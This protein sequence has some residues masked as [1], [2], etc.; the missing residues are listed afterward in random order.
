MQAYRELCRPA[1]ELIASAF[2]FLP[3]E[4]V[5]NVLGWSTYDQVDATTALGSL[6]PVKDGLIRPFHASVLDLAPG[7]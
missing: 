2:E 5:A 7:P 6:F 3:L 1:L 4:Y